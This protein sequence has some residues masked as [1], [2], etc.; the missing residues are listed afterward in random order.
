MELCGLECR[1]W[2]NF[3]DQAVFLK[4]DLLECARWSRREGWRQEVWVGG[5]LKTWAGGLLGVG[6]GEMGMGR[7]CNRGA[8]EAER[9]WGPA[10]G[11]QR[12]LGTTL[13]SLGWAGPVM[14]NSSGGE[15]IW[16]WRNWDLDLLRFE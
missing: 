7:C 15:P 5:N 16:G 1:G 9:G 14:E 3:D 10:G 11:I 13:R 8:G 2:R 6:D 4:H 12:P